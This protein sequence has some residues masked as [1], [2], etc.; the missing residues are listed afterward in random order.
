METLLDALRQMGATTAEKAADSIGVELRGED[1]QPFC[2]G[3]RMDVKGGL[4]GV[5][6]C[7][8]RACGN[9]LTRID[10]PHTNGGHIFDAE[11]YDA[12]GDEVW[13]AKSGK[14]G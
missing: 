7:K 14:C 6:Y 2:C 13:V 1:G 4:V 5:D 9:L 10:S 11:V 12:L 3:E 8:C